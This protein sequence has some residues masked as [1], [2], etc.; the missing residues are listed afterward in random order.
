MRRSKPIP[1]RVSG[2]R[3]PEGPLFRLIDAPP[4]DLCSGMRPPVARRAAD[5]DDFRLRD[6]V[7]EAAAAYAYGEGR[8]T[9]ALSLPALHAVIG[10]SGDDTVVLY[11]DGKGVLTDYKL[12]QAAARPKEPLQK[13]TRVIPAEA[14]IQVTYAEL[15]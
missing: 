12:N 4:N 14:G 15:P 13:C 9:A 3:S 8:S 7:S 2:V 11:F 5:T 6:D 1:L 10:G